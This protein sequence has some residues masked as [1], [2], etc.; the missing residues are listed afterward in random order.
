MTKTYEETDKILAVAA[1]VLHAARAPVPVV[2]VVVPAQA[3]A[4]GKVGAEIAM[5]IASSIKPE[6]PTPHKVSTFGRRK[7]SR[8]SRQGGSPD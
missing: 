6:K 1:E 7:L 3:G 4:A 5:K 8:T 2:P